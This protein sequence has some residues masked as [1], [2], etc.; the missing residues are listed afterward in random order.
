MRGI[1]YRIVINQIR[2]WATLIFY[3]IFCEKWR[4]DDPCD[5]GKNNFYTFSSACRPGIISEEVVG[6]KVGG[7]LV[8]RKWS[9]QAANISP[10]AKTIIRQ[11][12]MQKNV[13]TCTPKLVV[14]GVF[15]LENGQK[16]VKIVL[17]SPFHKK[18][19]DTIDLAPTLQPPRCCSIA[20]ERTIWDRNG[21]IETPTWRGIFVQWLEKRPEILLW[22][23]YKAKTYCV[24]VAWIFYQ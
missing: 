19:R 4:E 15:K 13:D 1:W 8:C 2:Y 24:G 22:S 11:D 16:M 9:Q 10:P 14:W 5:W 17:T 7:F 6:S 3:K 23:I 18:A 20:T 21:L 12:H